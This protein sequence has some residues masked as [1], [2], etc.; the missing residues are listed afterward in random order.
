MHLVGFITKKLATVN[1]GASEG[2]PLSAAL[3]NIHLD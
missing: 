1:K 2:F 3:C